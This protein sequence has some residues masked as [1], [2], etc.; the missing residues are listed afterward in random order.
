MLE[1]IPF[2]L[3]RRLIRQDG[4]V[5]WVDAS[6]SPIMDVTGRPQSAVAVEVDITA[7]RQAEE[8]L[9]QLNLQLEERV[10]NRTAKLRAANQALRDEITERQKA[11]EALRKSEADAR[12]MRKAEH[13]VRTIAGGY[14]VPGSEGRIIS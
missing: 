12:P 9:Q 14:F 1:G 8:A 4:S 13:P 7:R 2:K 5:I 11:E 10:L 6:V 3:E